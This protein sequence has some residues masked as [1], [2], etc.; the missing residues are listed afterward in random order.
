MDTIRVEKLRLCYEAGQPILDN[1]S[2]SV[3]AG[4]TV[5]IAGLSGCGKSSLCHALCGVVPQLID[6]QV[7]GIIELCGSSIAGKSVAELALTIALVFQDSDN[8]FICTTVEDELAFGLENRCIEP[9]TIATAIKRM[10]AYTNLEQY[11]YYDPGKLSGG[12]KKRA[13]VAAVNMCE[14]AIVI[15]DEPL[16]GLDELGRGLVGEILHALQARGTTVLIVEHDLTAITAQMAD[17]WLVLDQGSIAA[18][19]TPARLRG[20]PL[21]HDLE[22]L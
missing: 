12:E 14:P 19:D 9:D 4:E 20:K 2:F 17:R 21:L 8:Q 5:V 1:I 11:R 22:L 10:L 13:A 15:F 7:E 18:Y 3:E 16:S 6:A